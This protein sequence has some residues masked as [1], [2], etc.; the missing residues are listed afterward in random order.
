MQ[1][2]STPRATI[3]TLPTE[4]LDIIL[5]DLERHHV[6][7][8]VLVNQEWLNL[9][10]PYLWKS[11]YFDNSS[12][13]LQHWDIINHYDEKDPES[14]FLL[15]LMRGIKAGALIR[16]GQWIQRIECRAYEIARLIA[17]YGESCTN[18]SDLRIGL[19]FSTKR[20]PSSDTAEAVAGGGGEE[21]EGGGKE[22]KP[23]I[24]LS[25]LIAILE[26]NPNLRKLVLEREMLDERNPDY[27]KLMD[28]IPRSIEELEF[29]HWDPIYNTRQFQVVLDDEEREMIELGPQE[30]S[31]TNQDNITSEAISTLT[32][33]AHLPNLK[34]LSFKNYALDHQTQTLHYLLPRCPNL[35]TVKLDDCPK[36]VP[37]KLFSL[38]LR[39]HCPKLHNLFIM[40]GWYSFLDEELRDILNASTAGWRSLGL[41]RL[42]FDIHEFGPLSV[43]ALFQHIGTLENLR[44]D[45]N[46]Y[47]S[48]VI[49]QRILSSAPKLRRL[50]MILKDRS[51]LADI[52]FNATNIITGKPWDCPR[53]ESLKVHIVGIPRPDLVKRRN[54]RPLDGPM[55]R[56]NME[57]S[58]RIQRVVYEQLGRLTSLKQLVLGHD[59]VENTRACRHYEEVAE[60]VY[61]N[62]GDPFQM[63]HQYECLEMT[64]ESGMDAMAGLKELRVLELGAMEVGEMDKE[65]VKKNW[66]KLGSPYKDTFW[67]DLG[68]REYA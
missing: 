2:K 12:Q 57:E 28:S 66:P 38:L 52:T 22:G 40:H 8:C 14:R 31:P 47:L 56:G 39:Q 3:A 1:T 19:S 68:Y 58:R 53:L 21:E 13:P 5:S 61:Y 7:A 54:G 60:G 26:K 9:F 64:V 50:D 65:W 10:S 51:L 11:I 36:V 20:F 44:L 43:A 4:I 6:A 17:T 23:S 67:T 30:L 62:E 32:S 48:S 63:G 46:Y 45:G 18:L 34:Q 42:P 49:I 35:E 24:D 59:D 37:L 27:M 33:A 16:N 25:P 29:A 41:P 15:R 55:H